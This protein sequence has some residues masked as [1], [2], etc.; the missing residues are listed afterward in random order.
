MLNNEVLIGWASDPPQTRGAVLATPRANRGMLARLADEVLAAVRRAR[1]LPQE[2]WPRH[3]SKPPP[4]MTPGEER[5]LKKLKRARTQASGRL[6]LAP[7]LL[8]NTATLERI[9]RESEVDPAERLQRHLKP[10]QREAVGAD[11]EKAL[12]G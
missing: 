6:A 10:W 8:V 9:A 11:L 1:A 12:A 2:S 7:G 3:V 5:A 4:P